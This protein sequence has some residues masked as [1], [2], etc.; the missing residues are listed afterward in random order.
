MGSQLK[1]GHR[2][3]VLGHLWVL[4]DPAVTMAVYYLIFGIGFRQAADH[5][6]EFVVYLFVGIVT[7]RFFAEAVNQSTGCLRSHRGLIVSANFPKAVI[8]ISICIA[9]LYDLFWSML[10][11]FAVAELSGISLSLEILWLPLIVALQLAFTLGASLFVAYLGAFFADSANIVMALLRL[12]VL[13][14][15][16][17][18]FYRSEH[19]RH[20]I[21]PDHV[22]PYYM[23]NPLVGWLDAY[24]AV[25]V[26]AE[27]PSLRGL[28]YSATIGILALVIGFSLF[29]RGEGRFAKIV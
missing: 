10:V 29:S 20:G 28:A 12:W 23:L 15:P 21:I 16:I 2:H 24:R 3:K 25:L 14:S 8:P 4:L 18:Y 19:G 6:R 9:R 27:P 13:V 17:F 7:W 22:L 1:S 11:I 26:W 5:P